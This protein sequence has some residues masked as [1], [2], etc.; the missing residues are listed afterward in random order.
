MKPYYLPVLCLSLE[1][2]Q[3]NDFLIFDW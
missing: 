2:V 1:M 3:T